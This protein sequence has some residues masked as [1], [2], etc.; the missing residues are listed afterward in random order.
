[1][2][3]VEIGVVVI[4]VGFAVVGAKK[5]IQCLLH[6]RHEKKKAKLVAK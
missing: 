5:G 2:T 3:I 4:A 6:Y 1:M